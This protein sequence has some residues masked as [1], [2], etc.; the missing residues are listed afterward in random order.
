MDVHY[1]VAEDEMLKQAMENTQPGLM[2]SWR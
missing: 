2:S 1:M